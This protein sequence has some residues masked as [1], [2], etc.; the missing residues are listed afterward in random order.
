MS[1]HFN[2][3]LGNVQPQEPFNNIFFLLLC[4]KVWPETPVRK[5]QDKVDPE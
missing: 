5:Q 2:T 3:K 4:T 1:Y